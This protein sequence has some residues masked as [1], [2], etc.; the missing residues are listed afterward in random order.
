M[1]TLMLR[2]ET[3]AIQLKAATEI[4][5]RAGIV[6]QQQVQVDNQ[7]SVVVSYADV[8]LARNI[9]DADPTV[10]YQAELPDGNGHQNSDAE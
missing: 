3:H 2:G 8:E 9:I 5:D 1:R 6:A 10:R 4:L 7:V